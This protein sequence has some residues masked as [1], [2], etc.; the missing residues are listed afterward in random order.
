MSFN[1][2]CHIILGDFSKV[3][4]IPSCKI[5]FSSGTELKC[6]RLEKDQDV[7]LGWPH[8]SATWIH[9]RKEI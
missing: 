8:R 2:N 1:K 3:F 7:F 5:G 9:H 4:N 6:C